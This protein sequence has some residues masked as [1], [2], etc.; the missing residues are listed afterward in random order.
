MISISTLYEIKQQQEDQKKQQL[1]NQLKNN[2][3][4]LFPPVKMQSTS[5]QYNKFKKYPY[6]KKYKSLLSS[7]MNVLTFFF[8]AKSQNLYIVFK[9][10]FFSYLFIFLFKINAFSVQF[11]M[12]KN[13][14]L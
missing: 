13:K 7:K 5:E 14:Q 3:A 6:V 2:R 10:G 8:G 4:I 11:K 9:K 1:E 12:E